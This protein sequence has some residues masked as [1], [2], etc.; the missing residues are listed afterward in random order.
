[1]NN[2]LAK[3][4]TRIQALIAKANSSEH[5]E[6]ADAFL[7][8]AMELLAKHQL[9]INDMVDA[10]DP[11]LEKVG[12]SAKES[13][14]AWRWNL[15]SAVAR[16]Y[17]C[18]TVFSY[19]NP[20]VRKGKVVYDKIVT[21]VGRESAVM[22]TDLMYPWIVQQVREQAKRLAPQTGM[23]EQGQAKRVAAALIRRIYRLVAENE[24]QAPTTPSA[25]NALAIKNEV[26]AE[27]ESRYP[28]LKK[29]RAMKLVTD[30]A[31]RA[32]AERIG[33]NRQTSGKTQLKLK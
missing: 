22:T 18:R 33:L 26:E 5:P 27:F 30:S 3:V 17:G 29:G 9:D 8:K 19:S 25:H 4:K 2:E 7:A 31:S 21:A 16:F 13:G 1:M 11:I 14:H 6:E 28:N 10:G 24:A 32:A 20:E 23:S 12:L 15:Y